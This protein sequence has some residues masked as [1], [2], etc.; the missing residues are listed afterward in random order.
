[1]IIST[2]EGLLNESYKTADCETEKANVPRDVFDTP[3]LNQL[4]IPL[5]NRGGGGRGWRVS[6]AVFK[7]ALTSFEVLKFT[8]EWEQGLPYR[9][10]KV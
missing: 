5:V 9:V 7:P 6:L 1:M 8:V 10:I 3:G 4:Q 2:D